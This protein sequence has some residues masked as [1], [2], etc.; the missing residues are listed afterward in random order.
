MGLFFSEIGSCLEAMVSE[1]KAVAK[2]YFMWLGFCRGTSMAIL[3][4]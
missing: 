1:D 3:D 2:R 4:P